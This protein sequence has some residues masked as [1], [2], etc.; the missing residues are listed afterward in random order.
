MVRVEPF[1]MLV[2]P[3]FQ[4]P[5]RY[6]HSGVSEKIPASRRRS[7]SGVKDEQIAGKMYGFV[8]SSLRHSCP[9]VWH[10]RICGKPVG[11]TS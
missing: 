10:E 5:T 3:S 8:Q 4:P 6:T 7:C 2:P 1:T 11:F 9:G